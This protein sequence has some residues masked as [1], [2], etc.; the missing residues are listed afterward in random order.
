MMISL[1]N[2]G[3]QAYEAEE[4]AISTERGGAPTNRFFITV[5]LYE[6]R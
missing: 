5:V 2:P 4:V 3:E 6:R 1:L